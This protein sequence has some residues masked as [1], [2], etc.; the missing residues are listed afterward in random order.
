MLLPSRTTI[1]FLNILDAANQITLDSDAANKG[2]LTLATLTA[3][4]TYTFPNATGTFALLEVVNAFTANQSIKGTIGHVGATS[5]T[6]THG[7]PAT[8][9]SY[10]ITWPAAQGGASTVLTND[11]AGVLS[12]AAGGGGGG[13]WTDDGTVVRLTTAADNVA[14]GVATSARKLTVEESEG[15]AVGSGTFWNSTFG[16]IRIRNP[17]DVASTVAGIQFLMGSANNAL[18]GIAGIQDTANLGALGFFAGGFGQSSSV[19][20]RVRITAGGDMGVGVSAPGGKVGIA[21]GVSIGATYATIAPPTNGVIIEGN[22]GLGVSSVTN[23]LTLIDNT[24]AAAVFFRQN[25]AGD[26]LVLNA[27]ATE[28][29]RINNAGSFLPENGVSRLGEATN[30]WARLYLD[31]TNTGTV[32][33][34]TINKPAGRVNIAAAGTSVVVTNSVVSAASHVFAVMSSADSTGRVTSVVPAAGSFTINT[35]AV[36][37]QASFD[38]VVFNA[39]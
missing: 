14:I 20:E 29:F 4:R 9:T 38:F 28:R 37:A 5:G 15:T 35:V 36:T 31:Y 19:P 25:G 21:G 10:T 12:W 32:G 7:V 6:L 24:A 23:R 16:G 2:T 27:G 39:D 13:G 1:P 33:A 30:L 17:S 22:F 11:G 26:L 34:V 8:V 18:A 3:S